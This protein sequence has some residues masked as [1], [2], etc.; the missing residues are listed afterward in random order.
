MSPN[1]YI[2]IR[3]NR[4]IYNIELMSFNRVKLRVRELAEAL[5][6]D[7]ADVIAVCVLLKIQASSS[8]TSLSLDQCKMITDF[9]E[10]N[11]DILNNK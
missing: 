4:N 6:V 8:L 2:W 5:D 11:E 1:E 7:C 10:K 9:Y 3:L